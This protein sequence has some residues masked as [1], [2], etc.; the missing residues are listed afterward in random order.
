MRRAKARRIVSPSR[1][2]VALG[3]FGLFLFLRRLLSGLLAL[4]LALLL[5]LLSAQLKIPQRIAPL[6]KLLLDLLELLLTT[7]NLGLQLLEFTTGRFDL[8]VGFIALL[9]NRLEF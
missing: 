7:L 4:L 2:S 3:L 6:G 8:F 1:R 9:A 5:P